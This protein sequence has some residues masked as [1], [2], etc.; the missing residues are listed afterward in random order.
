MGKLRL[1]VSSCLLGKAVRYDGGHK[2]DSW[3]VE[4]LGRYADFIDLCPEYGSGLPVPREPIR[5]VGNKDG[6]R[7]LRSEDG[8]DLTLQL[9]QY[10]IASMEEL[11]QAK[12]CGYIL[13]S[14]SPTCG[15]EQ[16]KI[17]SP[18]DGTT[19]KEGIG[20]F[21]RELKRRFPYLP[22]EEESRLRDPAVRENFIEQIFVVKR[23]WEMLSKEVLVKDIIQFHTIHKYLIMTHSPQHYREMGKLVAEL[24][25]HKIADFL[26]RYFELLMTASACMATVSK[27]YNVLLHIFGY[28][29]DDL[30]SFEKRELSNLMAQ[31]KDGL[32]PLIV[33]INRINYYVAKYNKAYLRDQ[34]YLQ[35][36]S[37]EL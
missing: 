2:Y 28:F 12:L 6:Y 15:L 14:K 34:I 25:E 21:A 4:T 24:T 33:P 20:I 23:W 37:L 5:L 27:H 29:K 31:Y 18:H 35:T 16:V 11:A 36:H 10:S 22:V 19:S 13:K 32:I 17:Y 3:I 1:G 26:P 8:A 7:V 30:N 9:E